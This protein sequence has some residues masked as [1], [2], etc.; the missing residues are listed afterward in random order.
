MW[1]WVLWLYYSSGK[2]V[3][4]MVFLVTGSRI[5]WFRRKVLSLCFWKR[6][7]R[8]LH[9]PEL[10]GS[11]LVEGEP[12][13]LDSRESNKKVILMILKF[14]F[15][16]YILQNIQPWWISSSDMLNWPAWT[17]DVLVFHLDLVRAQT[18]ETNTIIGVAFLRPTNSPIF[19][20]L[21]P[22]KNISMPIFSLKKLWRVVAPVSWALGLES[23]IIGNL[24]NVEMVIIGTGRN[25]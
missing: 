9:L 13:E 15:E 1:F 20:T 2:E 21:Y 5:Y 10:Y 7:L 22:L 12:R 19:P 24:G 23:V 4:I 6:W 16:I 8:Y 25:S 3:K 18:S 14:C 17:P 11:D